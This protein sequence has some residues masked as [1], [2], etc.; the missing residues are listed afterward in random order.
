[1]IL[2]SKEVS[3]GAKL[4]YKNYTKIYIIG[5]AMSGKIITITRNYK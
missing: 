2:I 4:L 5:L 1:M 3:Q